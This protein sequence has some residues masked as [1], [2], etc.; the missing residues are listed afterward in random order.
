[1]E[2]DANFNKSNQGEERKS[3]AMAEVALFFFIILI[4]VT[5]VYCFYK[6]KESKQ[7]LDLMQK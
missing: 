6:I 5:I 1:L 2:L 4:L 7:H 3:L